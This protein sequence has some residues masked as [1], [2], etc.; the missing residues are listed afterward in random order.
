MDS[1]TSSLEKLIP[2]F[3]SVSD[4]EICLF[5]L[6]SSLNFNI[7]HITYLLS[8]K[9]EKLHSFTYESRS[10]ADSCTTKMTEK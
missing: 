9:K 3:Q 4:C 8:H 6:S 10:M 1:I 2:L 7:L 5:C